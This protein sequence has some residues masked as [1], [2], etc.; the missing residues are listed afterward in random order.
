MLKGLSEIW[1]VYGNK[2]G[3]LFSRR[4]DCTTPYTSIYDIPVQDSHG[5]VTTL[6]EYRGKVLLV[7]N[8]ASKCGLTQRQYTE[9]VAISGQYSNKVEVL[10]FPCNQ[11]MS[12]EPGSTEDVCEF[13]LSMGG[14]SFKVFD[15]VNVNGKNASPLFKYLRSHSTLNSS[16]IGWN[17]GK[18]LISQTGAIV[19]YYGPRTNPFEIRPDIEKLFLA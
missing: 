4:Q 1:R 5:A 6:A 2:M 8:V 13:V 14:Q 11:F 18:F 12:Q 19:G 17:F 3:C 9:L 7:V 10:A 16:T 15:K